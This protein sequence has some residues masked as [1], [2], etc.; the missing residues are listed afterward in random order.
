MPSHFGV[1]LGNNICNARQWFLKLLFYTTQEYLPC[2]WLN[3]TVC[4]EIH[5]VQP[6][7]VLALP[8]FL[9]VI[10]FSDDEGVR[11]ESRKGS[12]RQELQSYCPGRWEQ[13]A[14]S[15]AVPTLAIPWLSPGAQRT[16]LDTAK[17]WPAVSQ[18]FWAYIISLHC[19]CVGWH[20]QTRSSVT[21]S[22]VQ[23]ATLGKI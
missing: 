11:R 20:L 19:Q 3:T 17:C 22:R 23:N 21:N 18:Q 9:T 7:N 6:I 5:V 2:H 10:W 16:M 1:V 8:I 13:D 15:Q 14:G 12:W 4:T